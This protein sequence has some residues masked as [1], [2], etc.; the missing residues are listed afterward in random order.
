MV[1]GSRVAYNGIGLQTSNAGPA[2]VVK[3]LGGAFAGADAGAGA[4]AGGG[5]GGGGGAGAGDWAQAEDAIASENRTARNVFMTAFPSTE[6]IQ[7]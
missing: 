2:P 5:G 7:R 4:G 1:G 3:P 6:P